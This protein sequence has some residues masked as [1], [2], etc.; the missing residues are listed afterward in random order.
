MRQLFTSKRTNLVAAAMALIA[1]AVTTLAV[2]G[3]GG[4]A[5]FGGLSQQMIG[6]AQGSLGIIIAIAALLVG[7]SIGVVKQSMMAVV[8]GLG[9]AIALYY[10]PTVIASMLSAAGAVHMVVPALSSVALF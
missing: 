4:N 10:G 8:T 9:I 7:L 5:Q 2:A 3:S 6:W 1:G